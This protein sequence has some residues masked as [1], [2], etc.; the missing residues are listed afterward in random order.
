MDFQTEITFLHKTN[1]V[2]FQVPVKWETMLVK[3]H[4]YNP[5]FPTEET[6]K[7]I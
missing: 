5:Q 4:F 7:D 1:R 2:A 3:G 6:W